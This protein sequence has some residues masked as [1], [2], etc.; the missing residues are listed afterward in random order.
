MDDP[1]ISSSIEVH[2]FLSRVGDRG[3]GDLMRG[4]ETFEMK[5]HHGWKGQVASD[6]TRIFINARNY[7]RVIYEST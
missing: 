1:I 3:G 5:M 4:R 6:T 2:G 7:R